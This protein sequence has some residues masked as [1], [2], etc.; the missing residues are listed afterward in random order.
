MKPA[1][2]LTHALRKARMTKLEDEMRFQLRSAKLPI[3]INEW[4][5]HPTRKWRFDFAWPYR[6]VALEVEGGTWANGAHTRGKHY[7]SDCEK[8][9]E[10][11]IAGWK[12]IRVTGGM[13]KSG[14]ALEL[15]RRAL[16]EK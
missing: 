13:I 3:W 1:E 9:S 5:F 12:V 7:E 16:G 11:A 2:V 8:Y 14:L 15:V 4:T 6:N 10:A